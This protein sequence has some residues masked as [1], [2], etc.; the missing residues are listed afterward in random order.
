MAEA[1]MRETEL[2]KATQTTPKA[3]DNL[4]AFGLPMLDELAPDRGTFEPKIADEIALRKDAVELLK[5]LDGFS[6]K[7]DTTMYAQIM[8]H[9]AELCWLRTKDMGFKAG[10]AG[11]GVEVKGIPLSYMTADGIK[12]NENAWVELK[13][14]FLEEV[15]EAAKE[16]G[17]TALTEILNSPTLTSILPKCYRAG[18]LMCFGLADN[19]V[20]KKSPR[21]TIETQAEPEGTEF[22]P[23]V[24]VMA[25][26]AP[27]NQLQPLEVFKSSKKG[28]KS[29]QKPN[30]DTFYTYM[31]ADMA[32]LLHDR[33]FSM[34]TF[35]S[36][37]VVDE[38]K[39]GRL[40]KRKNKSGANTDT[41]DKELQKQNKALKE[42]NQQLK[43]GIEPTVLKLEPGTKPEDIFAAMQLLTSEMSTTEVKVPK[44]DKEK[45][46][47]SVQELIENMDKQDVESLAGPL[48][49]LQS[50][51]EQQCEASG[52]APNIFMQAL[53]RIEDI[54]NIFKLSDDERK[55][56]I[57]IYNIL[58][59][60]IVVE[61]G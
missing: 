61:A 43:D 28:A 42:E 10:V 5:A 44:E 59:K 25:P 29:T 14:V 9:M 20:F 24:H 55:P 34:S 18:I 50:A 7:G 51:I 2:A 36:N 19:R 4:P 45:L 49:N 31:S 48:S 47:A 13:G 16:A 56:L 46:V 11:N 3:G 38:E 33:M 35:S 54:P 58:Q 26:A 8:H 40:M 17:T 15:E 53:E 41:G 22:N 60:Q 37:V 21:P 57:A 6:L 23:R 32:V 12:P 27:M 30:N 39:T 1:A 52:M